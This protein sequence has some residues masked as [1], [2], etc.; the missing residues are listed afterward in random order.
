[1]DDDIPLT[2]MDDTA[3]EARIDDPPQLLQPQHT[4]Y[5]AAS[6]V[7][8]TEEMFLQKKREKELEILD[9]Q[10][11]VLVA[12]GNAMEKMGSYFAGHS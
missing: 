7:P 2:L 8:L 10:L 1:M 5:Q 9:Q 11:K 4:V 3:E 6:Q 12:M